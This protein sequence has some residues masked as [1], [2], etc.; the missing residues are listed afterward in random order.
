MN[1]TFGGYIK[2]NATKIDT[3]AIFGEMENPGIKENEKDFF[4]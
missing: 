1:T 3:R 2:S 4:N